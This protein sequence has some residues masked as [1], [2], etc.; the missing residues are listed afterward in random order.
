MCIA[1]TK[2]LLCEAFVFE[3]AKCWFSHDVVQMDFTFFVTDSHH[4]F[5]AIDMND[6]PLLIGQYKVY[7]IQFYNSKPVM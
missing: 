7:L 4:K 2:A 5:T 1:K 3:Y 6:T